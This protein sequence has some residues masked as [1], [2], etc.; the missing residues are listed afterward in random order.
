MELKLGPLR[1]IG[2]TCRDLRASIAW[3]KDTL[4]LKF[5]AEFS[6]PGIAFF[7]L[8]STRL[9]LGADSEHSSSNSVLY[10]EVTDVNAAQQ[11]LEARGVVFSGPPHRIHRDDT[12]TFGPVGAEEWM[13]FCKDPDGNTLALAELRLPAR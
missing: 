9:M 12:G 3:Y 4:G 5:I 7:Q 13:T 1:Q 2:I 6:P 11:A 10:F 8:G